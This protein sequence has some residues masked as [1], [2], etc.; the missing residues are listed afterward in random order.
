MI[1]YGICST[2]AV[3]LIRVVQSVM[4]ERTMR[5][6]GK[7]SLSKRL[8]KQLLEKKNSMMYFDINIYRHGIKED[9]LLAHLFA[10][11]ACKNEHTNS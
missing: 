9:K 6:R 8:W 1:C 11:N 2:I 3:S 7:R 5:R 4:T 10:L